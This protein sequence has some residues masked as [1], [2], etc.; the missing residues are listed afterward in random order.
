MRVALP[1]GLSASLAG[2]TLHH[3]FVVYNL[4]KGLFELGSNAVPLELVP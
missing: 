3:A 1:P 4:E 2:V